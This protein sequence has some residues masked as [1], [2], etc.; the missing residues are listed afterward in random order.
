MF[1][2]RFSKTF[3]RKYLESIA[4]GV[5]DNSSGNKGGLLRSILTYTFVQTV[6]CSY[7]SMPGN[8]NFCRGYFD[9]EVVKFALN[10]YFR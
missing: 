6:D 8:V 2:C 5:I 9:F 7:H 1:E 4:E 10:Q 3:T